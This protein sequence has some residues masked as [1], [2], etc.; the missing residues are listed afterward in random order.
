M[1]EDGF[2]SKL[3]AAGVDGA[4]VEASEEVNASKEQEGG[5]EGPL[6]RGTQAQKEQ[7]SLGSTGGSSQLSLET[8]KAALPWD[9]DGQADQALGA[10][11]PGPDR[12]PP[13][14][15]TAVSVGGLC[16]PSAGA[17]D[18]EGL[19]ELP[20]QCGSRGPCQPHTEQERGLG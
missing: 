14:P 2:Q 11:A 4:R 6:G 13:F 8:N 19:Q 9:G 18:Q 20:D 16:A 1:G 5:S 12:A 17:S 15:P 10:A 3:R 7:Q